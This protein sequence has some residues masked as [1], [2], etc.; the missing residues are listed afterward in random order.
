MMLL[1]NCQGKDMDELME[2]IKDAIEE[3]LE[4]RKHLH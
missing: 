2:N 1:L 3:A 4:M